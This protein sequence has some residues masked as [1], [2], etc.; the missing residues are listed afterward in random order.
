MLH[1]LNG[2]R[3]VDLTAI[4]L[5]PYATQILGDLGADVIKIEP[6]EGDSMRAVPPI[7]E[8]GLSAVFANNNRN[9]R[10]LALDL[11]SADGKEALRRLLTTADVLVHNMR[12]EAL[13]RLGFGYEAV[14]VINPRLIYCA[15]V[16]F[17]SAG[18]YAGRP[19]Y[20]D[21]IQAASGLAALFQM[22]DGTPALAPTIAADKVSGLHLVYAVLAALLNREREKGSGRYVEVPMF[23]ALAA[24]LLN[25]HLD[26]AT[27]AQDGKPGYRRVLSPNRKPYRTADGWIAVLPYTPAHWR[28]A[29]PAIGRGDLVDEPWLADQTQVSHRMPELYAM[30]ASALPAKSSQSWLATFTQLDIPCAPVN[31]IADLLQ[32]PHL[33]AVGF[34]EADFA[35]PTPIIRK[36]PQAVVFDGAA[37]SPDHLPPKLGGAAAELLAELGYGPD[38]IARLS[39]PKA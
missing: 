30:L 14:K 25:E 34:F 1:L 6:P 32:D 22:R 26:G 16:G 35:E 9:K 20:D 37:K 17:G 8:Q 10:S 5:G 2:I 12:Q 31:T 4:I 38:D 3:I 18:P 15:A 28:K 33:K 24:F 19:A 29:L 11:K 36:L 21:V 27:F 39:R 13:D 23:E 7:V